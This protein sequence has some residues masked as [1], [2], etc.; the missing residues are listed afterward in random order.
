[1]FSRKVPN[2]WKKQGVLGLATTLGQG[3]PEPPPPIEALEQAPGGPVVEFTLGGFIN[4][5][6]L[7]S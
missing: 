6:S 7:S 5:R 2:R 4:K 1:M 3:N